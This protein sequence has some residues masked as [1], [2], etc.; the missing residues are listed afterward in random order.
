M[1]YGA[2]NETYKT[3]HYED[4][5]V[6]K[7]HSTPIVHYAKPSITDLE[8]K[9]VLDAVTNGWGAHCYK[10]VEQLE[11][12]FAGYIGTKYAIATSSCTGALTLGLAAAGM[13]AKRI[14]LADI[15]WIATLAPVLHLHNIPMLTDIDPINWCIDHGPTTEDP[16]VIIATHLYGNLCDM[17]KLL[18]YSE[19]SNVPIIEDAAEALGSE[20]NGKKAGSMGLF[21][22][23]SFHGT[24][25]MTTGEGG[26]LVTNDEALYNKALT[27][28][29]HG[30]NPKET[31]MF[32]PKTIGYKF[33]MSNLQAAMGCA[34]LERIDKL[35]DRK[36][37]IFYTYRHLL[38]GLPISM[39]PEPSHTKNSYWM[40][41]IVFDYETCIAKEHAISSLS[42]VN[43]DARPFFW[44]L[45]MLPI[46][47]IIAYSFT[48]KH[49]NKN[50][51]SI[52]ARGVNLPN[53]YDMTD[54]DIK[55]ITDTIKKLVEEI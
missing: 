42:N 51:Y 7:K 14:M 31:R 47:E 43:V 35:V 5:T 29:N 22:V 40:P 1:R 36:R 39:N 10:Y 45:S 4:A 50:A 27:L 30:R 24:K 44:P 26:M 32:W 3:K 11:K 48:S 9:Y 23:F 46:P 33:K 41:T 38:E 21:G 49:H 18:N 15:N 20:Y 12:E 19:L 16:D 34:Q 53:Y 2:M 25:T 8:K 28:S 54:A 17:E 6:Y 52:S 13:N 55:L 37:E